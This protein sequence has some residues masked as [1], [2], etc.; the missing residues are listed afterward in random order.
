MYFSLPRQEQV[1]NCIPC[2]LRNGVARL[3]VATREWERL[4]GMIVPSIQK[5]CEVRADN[6][7]S[8]DATLAA[9][10]VSEMALSKDG[11]A[12][13]RRLSA[14]ESPCVKREVATSM[15]VHMTNATRDDRIVLFRLLTER[16]AE[17]QVFSLR[18]L[19]R[20]LGESQAIALAREYLQSET[21]TGS[22]GRTVAEKVIRGE[23]RPRDFLTQEQMAAREAGRPVY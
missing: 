3:E 10:I 12:I 13:L 22:L 17:T 20:G 14:H 7:L 19:L 1:K 2:E 11:T 9:A 18:A 23:L 4:I 8:N 16:D 15:G 5:A 21:I 6:I